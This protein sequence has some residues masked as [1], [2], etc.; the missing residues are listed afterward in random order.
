MPITVT[1]FKRG[2]LF[3]WRRVWNL[4]RH[5]IRRVFYKRVYSDDELVIERISGAS[6]PIIKWCKNLRVPRWRNDTR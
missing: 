2:N 6:E 4:M 5:V 3:W 1:E